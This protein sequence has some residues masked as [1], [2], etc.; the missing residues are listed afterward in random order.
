M[1]HKSFYHLLNICGYMLCRMLYFHQIHQDIED[2]FI[3][4]KHYSNEDMKTLIIQFYKGKIILIPYINHT[5]SIIHAYEESSMVSTLF[6]P[7]TYI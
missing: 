3:S 4:L 6:T 1:G 7:C 5:E 2:G